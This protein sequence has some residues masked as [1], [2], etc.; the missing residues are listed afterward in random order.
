MLASSGKPSMPSLH[1]RRRSIR[2][3]IKFRRAPAA[4][5]D[6]WRRLINSLRNRGV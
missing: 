2:P 6:N 4:A 5:E 3:S 1:S